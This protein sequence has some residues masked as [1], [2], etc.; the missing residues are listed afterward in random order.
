M[1]VGRSRRVFAAMAPRPRLRFDFISMRVMMCSPKQAAA[2]IA[3][4]AD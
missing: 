4:T 3:P 2:A 1:T